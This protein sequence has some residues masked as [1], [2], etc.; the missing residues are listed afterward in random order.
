[1]RGQWVLAPMAPKQDPSPDWRPDRIEWFTVRYR[2]VAVAVGALVVLGGL[3]AWWLS[4]KSAPEPAPTAAQ[5]V[6]TGARFKTIEGTVEVK[7][8]GKL[9]WMQATLAMVLHQND[10]VRTRSGATAVIELAAGD[11]VD[12]R[13]ETLF[14]I[15]ESVQ[16]PLSRQQRVALLIQAGEANF[17]TGARTVPA[18]TTI[19]TRTVRTTPERET[20]GS[21]Q[22]D[23]DSGE[24]GVRIFKGAGRAETTSGQRI[25]LASNEGVRVEADGTAGEKTTLPKVP[26]LTAPPNDTQVSYR[27]PASAITLL[28][29][30]A[31]PDARSYRVLVD[32][33]ATFARPLYDRQGY[34]GTQMELRG[35]DTGTYFWKVAAVDPSGEEGAFGGPLRFSVSR[36][37]QRAASPPPLEVDTLELKGNVLHVRGRTAPGSALT[38]DGIRIE[39]QA[40]GSFSEFVAFDSDKTTVL[41]RSTGLDGAAT[42]QRRPIVRTN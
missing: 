20:T 30:N 19:S 9:D 1:L 41:V 24:T 23:R 11:V 40:D 21:I 2:S 3:A 31:V 16:N 4:G 18:E 10:L 34:Q 27:D 5:E 42:Q 36:A 26:V 28:V 6:E 29:W 37:A 12:L 33:S 39:V 14:T 7:M 13:P 25:A 22:V 32:F 38:V 8:A 35:L 17:Q 15:V